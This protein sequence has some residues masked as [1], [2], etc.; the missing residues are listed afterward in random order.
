MPRRFA[1]STE[2]KQANNSGGLV[3]ALCPTQPALLFSAVERALKQE[4]SQTFAHRAQTARGWR[5]IFSV[6]RFKYDLLCHRS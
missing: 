6:H 5:A 3:L 2:K 1:E 4:F